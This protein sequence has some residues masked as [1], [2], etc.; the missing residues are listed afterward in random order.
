M[1]IRESLGVIQTLI[2]QYS[3][4]ENIERRQLREIQKLVARSVKYVPYYKRY[5]QDLPPIE[6]LTDLYRYPVIQKSTVREHG[7]EQFLNPA[8]KPHN[9]I[10]FRTSGSTGEPLRVFH[11]KA[12]FDYSN[13]GGVRRAFATRSFFPHYRLFHIRNI[14]TNPSLQKR[15]L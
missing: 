7:V 11:D 6:S 3:R 14:P 12:S 13:A 1:L 4:R 9:R 15:G 2:R 5:Y 8:I 10:E